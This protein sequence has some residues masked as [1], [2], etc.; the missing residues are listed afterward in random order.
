[1]RRCLTPVVQTGVCE[2]KPTVSASYGGL[3]VFLYGFP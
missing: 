3:S 2:G 1:M